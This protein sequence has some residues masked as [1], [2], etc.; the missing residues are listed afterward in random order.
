[1]KLQAAFIAASLGLT[2]A[3]CPSY[4]SGHGEC[5]E[6]DICKCFPGFGEAD[7]SVRTCPAGLS[8]VV[9]T[10]AE[11]AV[12]PT[13]NGP[14][15]KHP[16]TECSS[17]GTCD[18]ATGECDCFEG[19]TGKACRRAACPNDCSGHGLCVSDGDIRSV[20]D[21][22]LYY[23]GDDDFLLAP[24][25][26]YWNAHMSHQCICDQQFTGYDCSTRICPVGLDPAVS[27]DASAVYSD[28]QAVNLL[29]GTGS[30][31]DYEAAEV[32]QYFTLTFTSQF[33]AKYETPPIS[34]WDTATT[35]QQSLIS[36]PNWSIENVQVY[37]MFPSDMPDDLDSDGVI[38]AG[39]T[40]SQSTNDARCSEAYFNEYQDVT[41][42]TDATCESMF[43][44]L[45]R[46]F[47]DADTR[48]CI[49]SGDECDYIDGETEFTNNCAVNFEI[50]GLYREN[51][52]TTFTWGR[53]LT[54]FER[55]CQ[56]GKFSDDD[57]KYALPCM[58]DS[59][60][61]RCAGWTQVTNGLCDTTTNICKSQATT[62]GSPWP[63]SINEIVA[64]N[65]GACRLA[66][67]IIKFTDE[68]TQGVQNDLQCT[69]TNADSTLSGASPMYRASGLS[70]CKVLH[71]G[72]PEFTKGKIIDS[73]TGSPVNN[74]LEFCLG[75]SGSDLSTSM[76]AEADCDG[77]YYSMSM[78]QINMH[79]AMDNG[80]VVSIEGG[81][82]PLS[83]YFFISGA[84]RVYTS[85]EI[86]NKLTAA[87]ETAMP[88]SNRG[89]CD[90][91]T[92][93]C[94]CSSGYT[95]SAC[96][97]AITYV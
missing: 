24:Q 49:E 20:K 64:S 5:T 85:E 25:K 34:Y 38:S 13:P 35:V 28:I 69:I 37:K 39:D 3:F 82:Y 46:T 21:G 31:D 32:E 58:Q 95:G 93:Q 29:F 36:L 92:G 89:A 41:C 87:Y 51:G 23:G 7:C 76:V 16:Y 44:S 15:G 84:D 9:G 61:Q 57:S 70:D 53:R 10:E 75:I 27:C 71:I 19:Y 81:E 30:A 80:N 26:Q 68:S 78:D 96:D 67:F 90:Y 45:N 14:V 52:T 33:N 73:T 17:R 50:D 59:D 6:N 66:T 18:R 91:T 43:P 12:N 83:P 79:I 56:A 86:D 60:C 55:N 1:M 88:C 8:W 48:A 4:C 11:L 77:S 74:N 40:G 42:T 62:V 22:A 65:S 94:Q 47:C 63:N 72:V 2:Q 97:Q 54:S